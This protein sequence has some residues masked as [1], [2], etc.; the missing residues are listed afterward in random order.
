MGDVADAMLPI[1]SPA[2]VSITPAVLLSTP[3]V[4]GVD[5]TRLSTSAVS[6]SEASNLIV[7]EPSTIGTTMLPDPTKGAV[8]GSCIGA[9]GTC[10]EHTRGVKMT[11]DEKI[12]GM[13]IELA[14]TWLDRPVE[15]CNWSSVVSIM[16]TRPEL[17]F[18]LESTSEE[19]R[20]RPAASNFQLIDN[21]LAS[22][23]VPTSMA[24]S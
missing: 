12:Y 1:A 15:N 14:H 4:C 24:P 5:K 16:P 7:L 17:P 18:P 2:V 13:A 6:G 8:D 21:S 9:T 11:P 20:V 22:G 10:G 3:D 19:P 23:S